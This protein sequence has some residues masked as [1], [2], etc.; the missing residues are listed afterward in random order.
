VKEFPIFVPFEGDQVAAVIAVPEEQPRAL[1]VLLTGTGAT[2]SHRF[3]LWTRVARTLAERGLASAR[4]DYLGIGDSTG[5]SR[6]VTMQGTAHTRT[7]QAIARFSLEALG[8]DRMA[9]AGNCSGATTALSI[10]AD[11]PECSGAVCILMRVL[12][13]SAVDRIVINAR[14]SRAAAFVR[15]HPLLDRLAEPFRGRK[16][17]PSS[18]LAHSFGLALSHSRLLFLYS[19]T[20]TDAY[21][22]KAMGTL[23]QMLAELPETDRARFDLRIL[24]VGPIS[25]FESLDVQRSVVETTVEWLDA[26]FGDRSLPVNDSDMLSRVNSV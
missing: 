20:D 7:A 12:N 17:R 23:R 3:Q 25:E 5:S 14:R 8:V 22:E 9:V 13:P 18:S 21:N 10:A 16:G 1:V 11:M 24:P 6:E 19:E 15:S 2:R 4:L 26:C